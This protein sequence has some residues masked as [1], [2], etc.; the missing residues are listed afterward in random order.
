M[1]KRNTTTRD[2]HRRSLRAA[3]GPC[4]ICGA[5]I[6]YSL[7]YHDPMSFVA[8]HVISLAQGGTDTRDN[9]APAHRA[10]NRDKGAKP[11]A[12]VI[13]RSGSLTRPGA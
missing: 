8:D 3:A 11:F 10:C 2:Q 13:K 5:P 6:D 7:P 9:V 12:N 1:V 4:H